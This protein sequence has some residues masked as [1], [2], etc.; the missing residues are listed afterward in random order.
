MSHALSRL[1]ADTKMRRVVDPRSLTA[2]ASAWESTDLI[3]FFEPAYLVF[4]RPTAL[5]QRQ[6][7]AR[8]V[9]AWLFAKVGVQPRPTA[10]WSRILPVWRSPQALPPAI[11]KVIGFA[12][13]QS[14]RRAVGRPSGKVAGARAVISRTCARSR[15]RSSIC[16]AGDSAL[17]RLGDRFRLWLLVCAPAA[18]SFPAGRY[19]RIEPDIDHIAVSISP[20]RCRQRE[21]DI[22]SGRA[23][24]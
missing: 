6:T 5:W 3:R 7:G 22:G 17:L 9:P 11:M 4:R 15:A 21:G 13:R 20:E 19:K 12:G 16:A 8:S 14:C 18:F 1:G 23:R 24:R 2:F 10:S